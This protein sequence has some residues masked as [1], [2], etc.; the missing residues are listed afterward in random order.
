MEYARHIVYL[1]SEGVGGDLE[2]QT[3]KITAKLDA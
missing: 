2:Y 3:D 1:Y